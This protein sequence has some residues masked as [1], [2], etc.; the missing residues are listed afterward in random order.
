MTPWQRDLKQCFKSTLS[1]NSQHYRLH[2]C[3]WALAMQ[4]V[5][6]GGSARSLASDC[7]ALPPASVSPAIPSQIVAST[8]RDLR[9]HKTAQD[10][11]KHFT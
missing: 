8:S 2:T 6:W 10:V 5:R 9:E 4:A 7:Q 11:K 1:I 3:A